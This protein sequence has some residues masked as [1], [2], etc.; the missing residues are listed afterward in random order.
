MQAQ[1][2]I[3]LERD[4]LAIAVPSGQ[5]VLIGKGSQVALM[6]ALGGS[7]TVTAQG[8][9]FRINGQ[10]ADALGKTPLQPPEPPMRMWKGSCGNRCAAATTRRSRSTSSTWG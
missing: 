6:Q 8:R 5:K 9:M 4:T 2:T 1:E 10:D 3:T 7:F